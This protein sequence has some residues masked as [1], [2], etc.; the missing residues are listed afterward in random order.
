MSKV[1]DFR[2]LRRAKASCYFQACPG[3]AGGRWR[4]LARA[5][6]RRAVERRL[7]RH[8][9]VTILPLLSSA[10]RKY[11]L[12][13]A[14]A[15][16]SHRFRTIAAGACVL[17]A[18][19]FP[20]GCGSTSHA[21]AGRPAGSSRV[22][23][24]GGHPVTVKCSGTE[25]GASPSVILLAGLTKPLTTFTSIQDQLSRVTKVCSYDR[26]GEGSSPEPKRKQTLADS[27]RLLHELLSALHLAPHGIVLVGHS[28]GGD[29]AARYASQYRRT[30]QVK[31][32]V[33]LDA[34]PVG[35]AHALQRVIPRGAPDFAGEVRSGN[36]AIASGVN[37]ERLLLAGIPMT[38][39]GGVP[40]TVVRHGRPIFRAV[41][42]Y[43]QRME[44][45]WV[46]GQRK[47]LRLSTRSRMVVAKTSGHPI[48]LDQPSL[49]LRLVR[50]AIS[51]ARQA[52]R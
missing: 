47:W 8:R 21:T 33:L 38:P 19:G 52:A 22:L 50:Q 41:P 44:G 16:Q 4:L 15:G 37:P 30:H 34:T 32:V 43:G 27:A 28:L 46:K 5:A 23:R 51:E 6:P 3:M 14:K 35:F 10:S 29:V 49:T 42:K 12:P 45:I 24:V 48:Y 18:A 26:P 13:V 20:A 1:R 40:L 39:I 2:V 11:L 9:D 36:L 17:V 7:A 31:A 25:R